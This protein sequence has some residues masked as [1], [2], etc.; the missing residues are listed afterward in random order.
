MTEHKFSD[1]TITLSREEFSLICR[2]IRYSNIDNSFLGTYVEP[3]L[4]D[5]LKQL[6]KE[7]F[8]NG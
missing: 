5:F 6:D 4:S 1:N 8:P 7:L 3:S 2:K